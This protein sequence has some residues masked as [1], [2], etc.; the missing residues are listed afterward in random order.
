MSHITYLYPEAVERGLSL[1]HS[2]QVREDEDDIPVYS[3]DDPVP[4]TPLELAA[5]VS[6]QLNRAV[7]LA[8]LLKNTENPSRRAINNTLFV[9]TGLIGYGLNKGF[10]KLEEEIIH[11]GGR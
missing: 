10:I 7:T 6:A 8:E 11:W 9:I 4:E 3:I 5:R 1:N 2:W